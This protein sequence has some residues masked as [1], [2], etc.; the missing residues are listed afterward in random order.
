[1]PLIRR[2]RQY[3]LLSFI[4][5]LAIPIFILNVWVMQKGVLAKVLHPESYF[6]M[7]IEAGW[8]FVTIFWLL[9]A[10]WRG[11]WSVLVLSGV[12]LGVNMHYLV[13][14]KNY[15][16]AFYALFLLIVSGIYCLHLYRSLSESYYHPGQRWFEGQPIFLP[17]IEAELQTGGKSIPAR[18][19]RLGLEGCYAFVNPAVAL[20]L[21][22]VDTIELKLGELCLGCAVESV[23]RSKDGTGRGL[24]FLATSADQHKDIRDFLDRVRSSGYVA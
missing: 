4:M 13:A 17:R 24:R 12:L 19:S 1:M 20:G 2:P 22:K 10:K 16:L 5:L 8:V 6:W 14:T 3:T 23:S 7:G 15:A 18:V 21:D 11:F 9:K